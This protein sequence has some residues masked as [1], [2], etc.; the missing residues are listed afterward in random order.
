MRCRVN[1]IRCNADW[2][3]QPKH[4]LG[5]LHGISG[6]STPATVCLDKWLQPLTLRGEPYRTRLTGLVTFGMPMRSKRIGFSEFSERILFSMSKNLLIVLITVMAVVL[7]IGGLSLWKS[8][9]SDESSADS[10]AVMTDVIIVPSE[11]PER[12]SFELPPGF[13]ERSSEAYDKYYVR[14]D[15]SVIVTGEEMVIKGIRL[16]EYVETVRS[17]YAQTADEFSLISEQTIALRSGVN[18]TV[19]EFTYAI[20]GEDVHQVMQCITAVIVK[21]NRAYLVTC[22]SKRENIQVY[23][24]AFLRM[25]ESITIADSDS[26]PAVSTE[27]RL[28]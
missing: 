2:C 15:A 6:L 8:S 27:T 20:V 16:D 28:S 21:D 4:L 23:R 18:C 1:P 14:D 17:Q 22:K 24:A 3:V 5:G 11:M 13:T 9:S 10:T 19:L 12:I 26:K 25:I 7:L